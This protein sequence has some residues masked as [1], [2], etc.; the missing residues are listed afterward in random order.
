MDISPAAM[1]FADNVG[2]AQQTPP[3]GLLF[4]IEKRKNGLKRYKNRRKTLILA[5]VRLTNKNMVT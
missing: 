5:S 2:S 1:A 4:L 3:K